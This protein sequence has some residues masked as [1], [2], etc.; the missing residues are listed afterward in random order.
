M[1]TRTITPGEYH[2]VMETLE[3]LTAVLLAVGIVE[4]KISKKETLIF[5]DTEGKGQI[6]PAALDT[7]A[8]AVD[9]LFFDLQT[10]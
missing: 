2:Q 1:P 5:W 6:D 9:R 7:F 4:L 3:Q 10:S 8:S